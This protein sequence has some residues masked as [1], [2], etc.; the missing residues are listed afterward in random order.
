MSPLRITG[1]T[2]AVLLLW[3]AAAWAQ[4]GTLV[5]DGPPTPEQMSLYLPVTG[6]VSATVATVRYRPTSGST[7]T[8]AHPLFRIRPSFTPDPVA[9]AFAGVITGLVPGV[10]YT[11]EVTVPSNPVQTLTA[12]TRALPGPTPAAN[13][14][15]A[16]G[17]SA[18]QIQAAF[19]GL[20]PG[21]VLQFAAGTYNVDNLQLD[22]SGTPSQP[23]TIRGATRAGVVLRDPTNRVIYLFNSSDV[24]IEDMTLEGSGVDSGTNS[25]SEGIRFWAGPNQ[26]R[27]TIRRVTML[28][29]D[30]A[31]VAD[32]DVRQLLVYDCRFAG[33]NLWTQP[34][35]ETNTSWDDDGVRVP[36]QGNAVFNNTMSGFGDTFAVNDG[37]QDVAI[38]FYRND[39]L[40]TCDDGFE[41][42]YGYRNITFY[43]N[44]IHN[45][46]TLASFDPIRGGPAFVFRNVAINTGRSPFKLNNTN[47]GHF[48][49]NNTVVRT[50]GYGSGEGWGWN[51]SNNGAQRAWG[52]CN[53]I[54][55]YRGTGNLMAMESGGNDPIDFTHNAW[56]PDRSV[57]WTSSGGSYSSM[58]AARAGLPS[59]TPVFGT[60]TR[61]HENDVIS[62]ADPFIVDVVLGATYLTQVTT[63]YAPF[64]GDGTTPRSAGMPVPGIT[65]GFSGS[66]PDM[67]AMITGIQAPAWGDRSTGAP[68]TVPPSAPLNLRPR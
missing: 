25:S 15:I 59:T 19:D 42:D 55:I 26:E 36:G 45:S 65:D 66:A 49:Y 33:N 18:S 24:V 23:I 12:T 48:F 29:V 41:G 50:N 38:H 5:H 21:D 64:V 31:V 58:S 27:V 37:V 22:R 62:D 60:S 63:L 2:L 35:L 16:A 6:S 43:D 54:L 4:L 51:Q 34:F 7:W 52:Y 57:W 8:T 28:G 67:G 46:M 39:I 53:N 32:R 47:S 61:R 1:T 14:L 11:V 40:W 30:K 56:Y 10:S 20:N 17:S 3:P 68:D 44:R 13:K 9:D